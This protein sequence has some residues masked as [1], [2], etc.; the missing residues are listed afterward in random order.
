MPRT[1]RLW[2]T[3]EEQFIID[4][5]STLMA[6]EQADR[7][8][9]NQA[10]VVEKRMRMVRDGL[11]SQRRAYLPRWT[12]KEEEWLA[13]NYWRL[14]M[15]TLMRR[16]R[17]SEVGIVLKKR[18]LGLLRTDGYYTAR[19]IGELFGQDAKWIAK[20]H[21]EGYIQGEKAPYAFGLNRVWIFTEEDVVRFLRTYPWLVDRTR[22]KEHYFRS[23]IRKEWD[24]D[25][26]YTTQEVADQVQCHKESIKRRLRKGSLQG[27]QRSPEGAWSYWR[28]RGSTLEA[29]NLKINLRGR[30]QA[31]AAESRDARS[32]LITLMGGTP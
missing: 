5:Y 9:R 3:K 19:A 17:R 25:P 28:I 7:L 12:R 21:N 6:K 18:R 16:L 13:D 30:R 23:I 8:H 26:W 31:A 11:L 24:K 14:P 2:T 22:M 27:H 32:A 1:Y 20:L 15:R 4:T 10:Q 29:A